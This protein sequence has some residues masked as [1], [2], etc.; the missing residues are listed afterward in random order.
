METKPRFSDG[1]IKTDEGKPRYDLVPAR[2]E[3]GVAKAFTYG[4]RKY[5][6]H[7]W[8]KSEHPEMYYSAARRHLAEIRKGEWVDQESGLPHVDH[9]IVSLIMFREL[10]ERKGIYLSREPVQIQNEEK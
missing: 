3:E 2:A 10:S 8:L 4:A 9:A 5:E 1:N 6:D 7:N